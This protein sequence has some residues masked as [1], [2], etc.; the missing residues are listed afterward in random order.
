MLRN[1][2]HLRLEKLDNWQLQTFMACLCE[3]MYPNY[4][5]FCQATN[6]ASSILYRQILDLIWQALTVK[7]AK[8]N[9]DSQLAKLESAIPEAD[10]FDIYAVY[11]AIDA[12][13]ALSEMLHA[14]LSQ[15]NVEYAIHISKISIN[16]VAM[17]EMTTIGQEMT[18]EQLNTLPAIQEELDLQWE[19]FRLLK[20]CDKRDIELIKGLHHELK[21]SGI[22]NI[23]IKLQ[24]QVKKR[25]L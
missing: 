10:D 25:D 9:F 17:L 14:W 18:E 20:A 1:P 4:H 22:S 8:V 16:T 19:I 23:C 11:P 21:E 24:Q 2:L 6:F 12:C 3:R 13:A 15:E 5:A 7:D